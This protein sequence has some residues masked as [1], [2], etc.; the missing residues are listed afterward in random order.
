MNKWCFFA[1]MYAIIGG[2]V[3]LEVNYRLKKMAKKER[4]VKEKI[5]KQ[6]LAIIMK[7]E[8]LLSLYVSI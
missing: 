8:Y 1:M 4:L 7:K 6:Q 5:Q 3:L 2:I